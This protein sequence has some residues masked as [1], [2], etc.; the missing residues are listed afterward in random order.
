[1]APINDIKVS[2]RIEPIVKL[3]CRVMNCINHC[4]GEFTCN[5]KHVELDKD[6]KCTRLEF[7]DKK[8]K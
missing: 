6:G 8:G 5:L 4:Y 7:K 1:M 2:L 3:A